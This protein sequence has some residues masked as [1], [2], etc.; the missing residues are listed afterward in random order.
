M[1]FEDHGDWNSKAKE[2]FSTTNFHG[3]FILIPDI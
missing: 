1:S 3:R 2:N